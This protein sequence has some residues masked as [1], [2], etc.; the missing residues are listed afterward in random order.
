MHL[1]AGLA[2]ALAALPHLATAAPPEL[3]E[4]ARDVVREIVDGKYDAVIARFTPEMRDYLP[5]GQL[6]IVVDPLRTERGPARSV[7]VRLRHDQ[8]NGVADFTVK[9]NWTRGKVSDF[10]VWLTPEGKVTALRVDDEVAAQDTE[11]V[12]RYQTKNALRPPFHGT[13]TAKNAAHETKN[14]HFVIRSQRWAVDWVMAGSSGRTYRT[15]GKR[16]E[17]YLAWG[18][19]ALAP[20]DGT[21]A[22]VVDGIP[23]NV[24][25]QMDKYFVPGNHVA[26]DLGQGEFAMFMHLVPGSIVV[27]V[28]QRVKA[29][30][31]IG[32]VGNSGNSSEP[33]LH[34]QICDRARLSD[35][36]SLPAQ[37]TDV[38]LDG[39][40]AARGWP[41]EGS[42][43]AEKATPGK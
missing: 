26:L 3:D 34:F 12:D 33:H 36:V 1:R 22:V 4:E 16:N 23:E 42:R 2:L 18:Q 31:V 24:P 25:G 19:E 37:Y 10:H 43:L 27:K 5:R 32:R 13:W 6:A 30:D 15:D 40:P 7:I 39:K 38:I 21:V 11:R 41:A 20:A 8:A 14:P 28:G 9:A 29:G 17:D 35:C